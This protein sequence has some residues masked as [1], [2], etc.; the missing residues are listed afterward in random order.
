MIGSL[1]LLHVAGLWAGVADAREE[2]VRFRS[3]DVTI[4]CS[5][6]LPAGSGRFPAVVLLSGSGL[7][8][9]D[10]EI[11][12]FRPFRLMSDFLAGRHIAVLRCD[13]RGVGGSTGSARASTTRDFADDA[14]AAVRML[15]ARAEID[16]ARVGLV[17]HSEG[18]IA[19]ALAA[20]SSTDVGFVVWMAGSA[21]RGADI[22]S[23]QAAALS[24]AGGA[25]DAEVQEIL[26]H[27]ARLLAAIASDAAEDEL[28]AAA[29]ALA[30]AQLSA[31]P[32]SKR[33]TAAQVDGMSDRLAAQ[34]LAA[35]QSPWMRFFI[36]FDPAEALRRLTCPV[37]AMFGGR[38]LQVPAS[39]NLLRLNAALTAGGNRRVTLREYPDA[40]HLFQPAVTGLPAE[41]AS[42]P[43]AFVEGLLDD[44]AKW[45]SAR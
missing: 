24:R 12:G 22:L 33:P 7:Q 32:A 21:V 34:S 29:R 14:L 36:A 31:Q 27:H 19:A 10:S 26:R 5:L 45:I 41:Y 37:L 38:D 18:A 28:L 25:T 20:S 40:N 4:A 30:A 43:Q 6:A 3:G 39:A 16:A 42:L 17:G 11:V 23:Q 44:L 8:D 13:D 2:D 15:R 9:R 35:L 1:S